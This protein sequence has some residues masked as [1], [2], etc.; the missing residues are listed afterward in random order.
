MEQAVSRSDQTTSM[1]L[2]EKLISST[3]DKDFRSAVRAAGWINNLMSGG[4][5]VFL[6]CLLKPIHPVNE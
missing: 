4:C 5:Y 6:G 1:V 3:K 2:P